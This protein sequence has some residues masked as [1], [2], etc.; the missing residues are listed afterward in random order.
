MKHSRSEGPTDRLIPRLAAATQPEAWD[1]QPEP[2]RQLTSSIPVWGP[3]VGQE[4]T[5]PAAHLLGR[6]KGGAT[7][8]P[9]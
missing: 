6:G 5:Q 3:E 2:A 9:Y 8:Q 7:G 1:W 4:E